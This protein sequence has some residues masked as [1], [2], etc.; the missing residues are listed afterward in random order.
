M[1][2]AIPPRSATGAEF[3]DSV[4]SI[5]DGMATKTPLVPRLPRRTH[6]RSWRRLGRRKPN[7]LRL[8]AGLKLR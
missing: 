3:Y 2:E 4:L 5:A 1:H 6:R 7:G 8:P